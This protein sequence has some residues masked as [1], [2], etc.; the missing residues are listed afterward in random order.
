MGKDGVRF[1]T[2]TRVVTARWPEAGKQAYK[3]SF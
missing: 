3:P 2:E 1:Y